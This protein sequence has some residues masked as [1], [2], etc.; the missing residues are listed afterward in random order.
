M[1]DALEPARDPRRGRSGWRRFWIVRRIESLWSTTREMAERPGTIGTR[2]RDAAIEIWSSRGGGFYGLGY[3]VTFIVLEVQAFLSGFETTDAVTFFETEL[4]QM[5]FRFAWQSV[6]NSFVALAWPVFVLKYLEA[7]GIV[8]LVA[9]GWLYGRF[10][11]PYVARLGIVAKRKESKK[12]RS[13][14]RQHRREAREDR[15]QARSHSAEE[16]ETK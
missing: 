13:K 1:T 8:V 6:L 7:W 14:R 2:M 9:G 15:G 16:G 12:R 3:L 4:L 10:A 11:A 5:I